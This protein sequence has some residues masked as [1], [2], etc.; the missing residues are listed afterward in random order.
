MALPELLRRYA[1]DVEPITDTLDQKGRVVSE[2]AKAFRA[3]LES[4]LAECRPNPSLG[5][6]RAEV[7]RAATD[8][9]LAVKE[10]ELLAR[11]FEVN[12]DA[13][14]DEVFLKYGPFA[15][16]AASLHSHCCP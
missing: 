10:L 3:A 8:S 11:K 4:L 2:K 6:L 13:F 16:L 1:A 5:P 7:D 15:T 14:M 9:E 12:I